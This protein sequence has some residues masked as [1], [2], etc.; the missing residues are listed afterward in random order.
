MAK[1]LKIASYESVK[2]LI[3]PEV[4][5]VQQVPKYSKF[6]AKTKS[7]ALICFIKLEFNS[8]KIFV[9]MPVLATCLVSPFIR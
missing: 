4:P 1:Y 3:K 8:N 7:F 2:E 5:E 9:V 6:R